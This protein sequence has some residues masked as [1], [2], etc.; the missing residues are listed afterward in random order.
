[1]RRPRVFSPT[2]L[3]E[4]SEIRH[5]A[6]RDN[7][8]FRLRITIPCYLR[9]PDQPPHSLR[10]GAPS[11]R[12]HWRTRLHCLTGSWYSAECPGLPAPPMPRPPSHKPL[13]RSVAQ[14]PARPNPKPRPPRHANR[15]FSPTCVPRAPA[16]QTHNLA[17][18]AAEKCYRARSP[19]KRAAAE[20]ERRVVC[21]GRRLNRP[22][23]GRPTGPPAAGKARERAW[24]CADIPAT[25]R[26]V[27]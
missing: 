26:S 7:H 4:S 10:P 6:I 3:R 15:G 2:S 17:G 1:V 24:G 12:P 20:R 14:A 5:S 21:V 11:S 27:R 18:P 9:L 22:S 19:L 13:P 16:L 8:L 23:K 25:R